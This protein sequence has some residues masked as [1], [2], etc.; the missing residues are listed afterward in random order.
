MMTRT[1]HLL[2]GLVLLLHS[3]V[4]WAEQAAGDSET[5]VPQP[6][7]L[8]PTGHLYSPYLA[9]PKRVTFGLQLLY[10]PETDIPEATSARIA[11][12][13]GGR[14]ELFNWQNQ[15]DP[16]Q[17][18]QANLEIGFRG[19]FDL[20]YSQD[21]IGWDGN[22]GLLFSYRD[23]EFVSYRFGPYHT[24]SHVGDEYAE[25][26]GRLR[27]GYT[28]EELLAG[29]QLNL[30]PQW[31]YYLEAGYGYNIG[32]KPLQKRARLQTGIQFQQTG[33]SPIERL[34]WYAGLDLSSYAERDWGINQ[35]VQ[36]GF[37][38]A[39]DPHVWRIALDYYNG[40]AVIGEF[41][42][43]NETYAGISLYLD[44]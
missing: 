32:E 3:P 44:I 28:R 9:D 31:Q 19:H 29:M 42:Q 27:I 11:L 1:R 26:T 23:N 7:H 6:L 25:R 8:A 15:G 35:A 18:L 5:T 16:Q 40:Q 13:M 17:Q 10:V 36:I 33:F 4:L 22:Y 41:F 39:A 38:F 14:L 2:T 20:R 43:H 21:N 37:A 34:G 30:T 24:S 12:R